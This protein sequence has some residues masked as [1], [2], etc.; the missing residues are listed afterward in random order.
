MELVLRLQAAIPTSVLIILIVV[1]MIALSRWFWRLCRLK[2]FDFV[3]F[4]KVYVSFFCFSLLVFSIVTFVSLR[5]SLDLPWRILGSLAGGFM[6]GGLILMVTDP[7][8]ISPCG[9]EL[10]SQ[11]N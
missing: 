1:I 3:T 8:L 11:Q 4:R 6:C 9:P 10:E 2:N 7:N 5:A